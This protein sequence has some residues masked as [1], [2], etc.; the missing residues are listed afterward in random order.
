[1]GWSGGGQRSLCIFLAL[2]GWNLISHFSV[3]DQVK[4]GRTRL[5]RGETVARGQ[6][7]G[8][9]GG[10][11]RA[12]TGGTRT[13]MTRGPRLWPIWCGGRLEGTVPPLDRYGVRPPARLSGVVAQ[14]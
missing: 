9:R 10:G 5:E 4:R 12:L 1:M 7:G 8:G 3:N 2:P 14:G 6:G 11:G 13:S